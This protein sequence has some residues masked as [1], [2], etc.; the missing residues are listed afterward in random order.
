LA[1]Y[2]NVTAT[3]ALIVALGGSA[4]A[5][6]HLGKDSVGARQIKAGAVRSAEVKDDSLTGKDIDESK[7]NQVPSAANADDAATFQGFQPSHFL[8]ESDTAVNA[9]QLD[10]IDSTGFLL[11]NGKATDADKLDGIDSSQFTRGNSKVIEATSSP[12]ASTND[13]GFISTTDL[14][15]D[16]N[17]PANPASNPST[18]LVW[19]QGSAGTSE[20]TIQHA[21]TVS[22]ETKTGIGVKTVDLAAAGDFA[23]VQIRKG[24][25]VSTIWISAWNDASGCNAAANALTVH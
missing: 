20:I 2:A 24:T 16:F 6:V 1:N 17:C 8:G 18:V 4:Y 19:N 15:L 12:A 5:A 13:N 25:T 10:G 9:D 23:T 21:G 22:H 3:L 11:S 14:D 7:L